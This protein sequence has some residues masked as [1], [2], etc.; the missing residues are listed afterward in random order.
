MEH[1]AGRRVSALAAGLERGDAESLREAV[2]QFD[3]ELVRLCYLMVGDRERKPPR[4]RDRERLRGWLQKVAVNE[5]RQL[6]RKRDAGARAERQTRFQPPATMNPHESAVS[7][8]LAVILESL[9][10]QERHL[11]GLRFILDL[12]AVQ[13]GEQLGLSPEGARSRLHRLIKR[14]REDIVNVGIE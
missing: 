11:L 5:V 7:E 12:S 10:E 9:D 8:R 6:A 2:A 1:R 4:L 13:I 3:D 14:I